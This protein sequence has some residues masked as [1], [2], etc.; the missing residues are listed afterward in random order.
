MVARRSA[1]SSVEREGGVRGEGVGGTS[2]PR[3]GRLARHDSPP[4]LLPP[5]PSPNSWGRE[6]SGKLW[7][8]RSVSRRQLWTL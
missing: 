8:R 2:G 5:L 6:S 3:V 7:T 4:S 1:A